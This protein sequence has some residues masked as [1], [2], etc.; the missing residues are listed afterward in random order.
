MLR[1]RTEEVWAFL[2]VIYHNWVPYAG[3]TFALHIRGRMTGM[4]WG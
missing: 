3:T 1:E 2:I 4:G